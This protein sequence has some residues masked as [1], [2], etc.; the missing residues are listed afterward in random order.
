MTD[1]TSHRPNHTY[2]I[3]SQ[4][5]TSRLTW[6]AAPSRSMLLVHDMQE[7][8]VAKYAHDAEPIRSVID[9]ISQLVD[10]ARRVGVPV[11][12]SAQ[13]GDQDPDSR[14]LLTDLWGA[15]P[16]SSAIDII[17]AFTPQPGELMTKH[18]Y[19][20]FQRTDLDERIAQAGCDTLVLTG[21][22]ANIGVK[23]TALDAFM[24]DIRPIVIGDAVA[25][26]D[27]DEHRAAL[28]WVAGRCG[29][30]ASTRSVLDQW[31]GTRV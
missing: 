18:R 4:L 10:C 8:F 31:D 23:A 1:W 29:R 2:A 22:Y 5:P 7:H 30:I 17:D 6:P 21:I 12:F 3:P 15:G 24:R 28:S 19:S 13:P 9:R 27:L 11:V 16:S 14:G 20:A 26:F 25:D